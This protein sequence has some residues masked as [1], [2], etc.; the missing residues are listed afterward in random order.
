MTF[1]V[2]TIIALTI[3]AGLCAAVWVGI[4][5]EAAEKRRTLRQEIDEYKRSH[6]P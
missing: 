3:F 6:K 5:T 4:F 1:L 2:F